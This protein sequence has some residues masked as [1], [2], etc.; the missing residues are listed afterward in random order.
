MLRRFLV[1]AGLILLASVARA[2]RSNDIDRLVV[3]LDIVGLVEVMQHEGK[4]FADDIAGQMLGGGDA[5]WQTNVARLY[6]EVAMVAIVRKALERGVDDSDLA[7]LLR[8]FEG[9]T[10]RRIVGLE[11]TARRAMLDIAV[12]EGA[13]ASFTDIENSDDPR[14]ALLEEFVET[15]DLI[16]AN[17]A[18]GLSS[19]YQFYRG[20]VD[21]GGMDADEKD[22][23]ADVWGQEAEIRAD[24]REW[25][26]AFSLMA[27]QP[28]SD[29]E[30]RAYVDLSATRAGRALNQA[31]FDGF[32]RMYADIAYGLGLA[33]AQAM[34]GEDL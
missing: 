28:L 8:F 10:G 34:G 16:E 18:G 5:M 17:V 2:D 11:T 25:V 30:L 24:T 20:L 32:D 26:F 3:A 1:M 27:Y 19:N 14:L 31:L 7:A 12:E 4:D 22:I 9:D 15:N 23:L 13:R 33:A 21:G 29:D 6:D